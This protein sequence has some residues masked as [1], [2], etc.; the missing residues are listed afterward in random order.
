MTGS[1]P[2]ELGNMTALENINI[3]EMQVHQSTST[4]MYHSRFD[5]K[6]ADSFYS[7]L[8]LCLRIKI[9]MPTLKGNNKLTGNIPKEVA[10]IGGLVEL[11]LG[12]NELTGALPTEIGLL[13]E[14]EVIVIGEHK[15]LRTHRLFILFIISR[16]CVPYSSD[17]F[18][19][20]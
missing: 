2:L 16:L 10:L 12:R 14:L 3:G 1:I 18:P 8:V 17:L 13:N 20:Y 6:C 11:Q 4:Y 5:L 7:F 19:Q 9:A 15:S